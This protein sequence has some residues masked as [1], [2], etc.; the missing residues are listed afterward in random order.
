MNQNQ[1]KVDPAPS[2]CLFNSN[3]VLDAKY[4]YEYTFWISFIEIHKTM[5]VVAP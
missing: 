1:I 5:G 3:C 2:F 4:V